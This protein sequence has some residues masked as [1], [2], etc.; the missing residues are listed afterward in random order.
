MSAGVMPIAEGAFP[1][2]E[3]GTGQVTVNVPLAQ[4]YIEQAQALGKVLGLEGAATLEWVLRCPGVLALDEPAP[5]SPEEGWPLLAEALTRAMT[6]LVARREAEGEALR[7]ELMAL[8]DRLV[9][10]TERMAVRASASLEHRQKRLRERI[11]ALLGDATIDEGR[12]AMEVAIWAERADIT[13]ELAR[14][15]AH[16]AE[17]TR[18]LNDGGSV[19]RTLDFLIQEMNR[20]TNTVASKA[21]DLELSQAAVAAK[22]LLEKLREQVQN[23]E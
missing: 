20:E 17:F 4:E 19:G 13:E 6:E 9:A 14:L 22:S 23:L 11:A 12:L 21:D 18:L 7:K 2:R 10:E 15:K 3:R 5:V 8:H 16:L 1:E